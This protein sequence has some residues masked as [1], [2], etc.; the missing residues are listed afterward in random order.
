MTDLR[1]GQAVDW[2][3]W[4]RREERS[5]PRSCSLLS[6]RPATD[7]TARGGTYDRKASFTWCGAAHRLAVKAGP[8]SLI[9]ARHPRGGHL[10][11]GSNEK[12]IRICTNHGSWTLLILIL[13]CK[14]ETKHNILYDEFT[15]NRFKTIK[16]YVITVVEIWE[17]VSL[18]WEDTIRSTQLWSS[19]VTAGHQ[20]PHATMR[21]VT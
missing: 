12:K 18:K 3:A 21:M 8:S 5:W 20:N 1:Q 7:L 14:T 15:H 9:P 4:R 11:S 16:L 10:L 2:A 19:M 13:T 6:A 17:D